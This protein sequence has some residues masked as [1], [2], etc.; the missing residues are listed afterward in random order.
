MTDQGAVNT[1]NPWALYAPFLPVLVVFL[2]SLVFV[3][4]KSSA[5]ERDMRIAA[6]QNMLWVVTQTQMEVLSLTLAVAQPDRDDTQISQRFDLALSRLNL[7]MDGPQARYLDDIGHLA[8]VQDMSGALLS[9]D[10]LELGHSPDLHAALF[11][12]GQDLHPQI[13]RIANDVMTRDWD[14]SAA[15]LDA[16]RATQRLII[17]AVSFAFLAALAISWLLLRNQRRLHMTALEHMRAANLLEQERDVSAMYRDFAAIVS[18]QMRTPLS[19]ID[20]SM[21]RLARMGDDVAASDVEE[22]R[23]IVGDA[24]GRL[25]RLVDTVLLLAKLDNDQLQARFAPLAMDHVVQSIMEEAQS[26]HPRRT[27]RLSCSD[28][29]LVARGDRHLV[30][31]IIDNLLSNALKYSPPDSP[32]ELRVF[33]QGQ[34]V[35]CA[36]TDQGQGIAAQDRTYLFNRYFRGTC[37]EVRAAGQGTG[38]GLALAQELAQLQG[39]RIS[40][41]TWAG[42]GSVFTFWLPAMKKGGDHASD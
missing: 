7:L 25:T 20:S 42:K 31:H 11:D 3:L 16:Y 15:R 8:A 19:L 41:E 21:H 35:A 12:L 23:K 38:L 6:T 2:G 40:F 29:P 18:H 37:E 14:K 26:R 28:G 4:A 33:T 22:R 13:N 39:G 9:L 36:V 34:D 32:I 30:G 17:A 10:P 1:H 24:V 27:L 5:L